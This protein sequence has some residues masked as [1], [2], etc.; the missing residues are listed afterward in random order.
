MLAHLND[1]ADERSV[2]GG[3]GDGSGGSA[4][5]VP[6]LRKWSVGAPRR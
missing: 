5:D 2:D 1:N 4:S 6:Q 3:A